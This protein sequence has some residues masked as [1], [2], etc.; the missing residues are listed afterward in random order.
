MT[1]NSFHLFSFFMWSH[2]FLINKTLQSMMTTIKRNCSQLHVVFLCRIQ[3]MMIFTIWF[4]VKDAY[5]SGKKSSL[6]YF[7]QN[8][9]NELLINFV[10]VNF[11]SLC[12]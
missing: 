11:I 4:E 5:Y 2:I 10:S 9:I 1:T 12:D 6:N 7:L 3:D 8:F